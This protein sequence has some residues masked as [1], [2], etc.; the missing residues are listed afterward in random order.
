MSNPRDDT[1]EQAEERKVLEAANEHG[2][3]AVQVG[4]APSEAWQL[5]LERLQLKRWV[6]LIDVTSIMH[7]P[8]R[9]MRIFLLS[10]EALHFIGRIQ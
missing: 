5:A 1:P 7:S 3:F 9:L 6:T 10:E 2:K 4:Y 8:G